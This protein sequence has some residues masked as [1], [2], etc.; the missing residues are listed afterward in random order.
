MPSGRFDHGRNKPELGIDVVV[1]PVVV[2]SDSSDAINTDHSKTI[3]NIGTIVNIAPSLTPFFA[4][5]LFSSLSTKNIAIPP[6]SPK[7]MGNR[8]HAIEPFSCCSDILLPHFFHGRY[9]LVINNLFANLSNI[10]IYAARHHYLT[11][12]SPF[13]GL[14]PFRTARRVK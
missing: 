14:D 4:N 6:T 12:Q 11:A 2:K 13:F 3:I 5:C 7:N 10:A 9:K 8:Y 1:A